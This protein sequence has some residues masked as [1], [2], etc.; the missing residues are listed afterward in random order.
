MSSPSRGGRPR[1]KTSEKLPTG[2]REVDGKF[3]W[4]GTDEATLAVEGAL[5]KAG[6][7]RR[8][9][10][11]VAETQHWVKENVEPRLKRSA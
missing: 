4:R 1:T 10:S 3:Y 11:T 7:S 8:C 9:G 2:V 5:R 6:I